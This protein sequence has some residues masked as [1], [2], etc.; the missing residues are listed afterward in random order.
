MSDGFA[1]SHP[2]DDAGSVDR[3]EIVVVRHEGRPKVHISKA[4]TRGHSHMG[5]K[6]I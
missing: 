2:A 5:S 1:D 6:G 3:I 4:K